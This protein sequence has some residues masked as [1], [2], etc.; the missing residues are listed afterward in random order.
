MPCAS[1]SV[2][3]VHA[4][5]ALFV[6]ELSTRKIAP[7]APELENTQGQTS[8][9]PKPLIVFSQVA[10]ASAL[11]HSVCAYGSSIPSPRRFDSH[12]GLYGSS[13]TR[14]SP[15]RRIN[16][17][18]AARFSTESVMPGISGTRGKSSTWASAASL[19]RLSW[20]SPL[21]RPQWAALE[22]DHAADAG[23][24]VERVPLD[25]DHEGR[26][27]APACSAPSV[28]SMR[29]MSSIWMSRLSSTK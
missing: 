22:E 5:H 13:E 23:A 7:I 12:R 21:F 9:S 29:S 19:S 26:Q 10:T 16:S 25:V 17:P 11:I 6:I 1:S 28:W 27:C 14:L 4:Y 8:V 18:R 2:V 15:T 3:D 24:V 20:M